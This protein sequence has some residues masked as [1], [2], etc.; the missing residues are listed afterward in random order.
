MKGSKHNSSIASDLRFYGTSNAL[1]AALRIEDVEATRL[2][3]TSPNRS[4]GWC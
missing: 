1:H 3:I 4:A 2:N